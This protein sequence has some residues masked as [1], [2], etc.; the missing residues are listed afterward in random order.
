MNI[1][2]LTPKFCLNKDNSKVSGNG[3]LIR[4][5]F[6][7]PQEFDTVSFSGKIP[8]KDTLTS[9]SRFCDAVKLGYESRIPAYKILAARLMDAL[10][11]TARE[12]QDF[13]LIFDREYCSEEHMVKG[14]DSFISKFKRS[15]SAPSDRVRGTLFLENLHDLSI[16]TDHILPAFERRG[17][18]IAMVPDKRQGRKVISYKPDFDVRLSNVSEESKKALPEAFRS[19]ASFSEQASGYGDIQFKLID[20]MSLAKEKTPLE[21][22]IVAGKNTANAKKDESYYVYDIV[23]ALKKVLHLSSIENPQINTPVHRIQNN[24]NIIEQQLND[25]ISKPLYENAKRLDLY[26]E[27]LLLPVEL[28][29][30]TCETLRGLAEGIR[31]RIKWHYN[32]KL[33]EVGSDEYVQTIEKLVRNSARF[34]ERTDKTIYIQDIKEMRSALI[35]DLKQDKRE[36][37]ELIDKVIA[38]LKETIMKYGKKD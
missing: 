6:S 10:E 18:Q 12:L 29:Q 30:R 13:G 14:V 11:V 31:Q 22:I 23:R 4:Y 34:K 27:D 35:K 8:K 15:G 37:I 7:K 28:S 36:D 17:Y 38:R 1:K 25:Y 2:P 9:V 3:P 26:H 19:A 32:A 16:F 21:V 5:N 20:T 33:K 24:I